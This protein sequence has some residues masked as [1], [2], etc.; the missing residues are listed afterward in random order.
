MPVIVDNTQCQLGFESVEPNGNAFFSMPLIVLYRICAT[1]VTNFLGD[2]HE[3][4]I[5]A[6]CKD[7]VNEIRS[8][9]TSVMTSSLCRMSVYA[10]R[11]ISGVYI[12]FHLPYRLG[13]HLRRLRGRLDFKVQGCLT[14]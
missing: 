13:P 5:S 6:L 10:V 11:C 14:R 7:M 12:E 8:I 1:T 3:S 4:M 2:P 9:L